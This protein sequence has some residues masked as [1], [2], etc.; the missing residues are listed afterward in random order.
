MT[1]EKLQ[2]T[3]SSV[4]APWPRRYEREL[5][6]VYEDESLSPV[7]KSRKLVDKVEDLG[8]Q[9]YEA[10]DPLPQL[11]EKEEVKLV[12]WMVVTPEEEGEDEDRPKLMSQVT[13]GEE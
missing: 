1:Q 2:K 12:C 5:R 7:E 6:E 13:F 10:P 8:L 9:P 3:V 11:E 4:E